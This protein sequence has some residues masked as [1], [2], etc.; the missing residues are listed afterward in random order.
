LQASYQS[1]FSLSWHHPTLEPFFRSKPF[2][3]CFSLPDTS[4]TN[5]LFCTILL[6]LKLGTGP[7]KMELVVEENAK[8]WLAEQH[9]SNI[10]Q[11]L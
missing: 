5:I 8:P 10:Q 1:I 6:A 9:L 2:H 4:E 3:Y 7:E 11:L